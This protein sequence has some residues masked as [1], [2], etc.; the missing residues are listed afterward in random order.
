[1]DPPQDAT[2]LKVSA[3]RGAVVLFPEM[4]F[5]PCSVALLVVVV[6]AAIAVAVVVVASITMMLYRTLPY[7]STKK[8]TC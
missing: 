3:L 1:M 4:C 6:I 8:K 7:E 5:S 2:Q